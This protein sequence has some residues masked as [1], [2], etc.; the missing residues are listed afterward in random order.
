M[1]GQLHVAMNP[2]F[3]KVYLKSQNTD[4]SKENLALAA[5]F[6]P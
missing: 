5:M 4:L 2:R 6:S 3:I 1:E